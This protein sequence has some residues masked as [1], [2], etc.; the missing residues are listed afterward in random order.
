M[1]YYILNCVTENAA[2]MLRAGLWGVGGDEKHRDALSPGDLVLI[3]LAAPAREFIGRA[4]I[5]STVH[6]WTPS[7]AG[8]YPGDSASGVR[9]AHIEE[10]EPPVPM[11]SVLAHIDRSAGARADFDAG[12]VGI[13]ADEYETAVA[14]AAGSR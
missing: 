7:E 12:V 10:W 8:T 4:E 3:Y 6:D 13:T 9:L 14:V 2:S 5:A 11:A 1:A